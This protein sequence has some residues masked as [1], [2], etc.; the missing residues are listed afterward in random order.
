MRAALRR[1]RRRLARE[2]A[3]AGVRAAHRLPL[4]AL[5]NFTVIGGYHAL[6][7]EID[8]AALIARLQANGATLALPVVVRRRGALIFRASTS[9]MVLTPDLLGIPAPSADA[10][11]VIPDLVIAPLIAFDRGGRRMG[12]GAGH[13]DSTIA[14]LRAAGPVFVI[15]LAYAGQE[16]ARVFTEAHDQSMD[17]ILTEDEYFEI[18]RAAL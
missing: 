13:Y 4:E 8:P 17:A 14:R 6:G 12:Q 2:S 16:V 9:Q 11:L 1:R 10:P 3:D 15:G 5:P 18:A 7:S